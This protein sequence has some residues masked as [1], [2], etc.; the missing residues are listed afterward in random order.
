ML[1]QDVLVL[2]RD[3]T[4]LAFDPLADFVLVLFLVPIERE[5]TLEHTRAVRA[6]VRGTFVNDPPV[7]FQGASTESTTSIEEKGGIKTN[8]LHK[9]LYEL[10]AYYRYH[11]L[12]PWRHVSS[13]C[14]IL[15]FSR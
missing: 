3:T 14:E 10:T 4:N 5:F 15:N 7:T 6:H 11:R 8:N 1:R 9:N 2:E 12:H 13:P